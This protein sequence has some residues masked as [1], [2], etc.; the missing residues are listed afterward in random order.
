MNLGTILEHQLLE[1][2]INDDEDAFCELYAIYKP[3]LLL[4]AI[5][6]LKSAEYA[7][8][9]VQE[10]FISV[11]Q[12]RFNINPNMPF[13]PY[14]YTIVKNRI[15]NLL[16]RLDKERDLKEVILSNAID[17]SPTAEDKIT[18]EE[19][20]NLFREALEHL[21]PKQRQVFEMSRTDMMSHREIADQLGISIYTVQEHISASI[22]VFRGIMENLYKI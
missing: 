15:L 7:E 8:D 16:S 17:S 3:K 14:V 20:N 13:S 11:W 18:A 22:K 1:R 2:L 10:A 9:I 5:K 19:I 6:Y 21:T 12:N 4:F